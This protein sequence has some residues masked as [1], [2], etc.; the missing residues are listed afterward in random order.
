VT[1]RHPRGTVILDLDGV[2]YLDTEGIPGAGKALSALEEDGWQL[3]YATNNS[4]K[5]REMVAR[6]IEERT[7]F[8]ASAASAITSGMAAG[9]YIAERHRTASVVGSRAL[10]DTVSSYG[11]AVVDSATPDAVVIGLDLELSYEK[12]DRASRAI[13]NGAEFVATNVDN[14][15]PTPTGLAPGAGSIV[16]AIAAAADATPISCGKPSEMMIELLTDE[17]ATDNV[18]VVGDRP[19]TDLALAAA[20]GWRSVLVL[21]GVA[22]SA[23]AVPH[24]LAPHHV[25]DSIADV[26]ALLT[27]NGG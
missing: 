8:Q 23:E 22:T 19:E 25:V 20:G 14:T 15:Y 18:W 26:P 10:V 6:H 16:A 13:R 7:G 11:V 5:T 24:H 27:Q 3:L 4:T 2:V 1:D 12:I 9:R 17:I 21:T